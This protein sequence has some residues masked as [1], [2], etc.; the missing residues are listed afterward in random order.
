MTTAIYVRVSSGGQDTASQDRD[1]KAWVT[2]QQDEFEFYRDKATGTMMSR[3]AMDRL[4]K[5]IVSG[6]ITKVVVWRLDRLGRTAQGLLEFFEELKWIKCGFFSLRDAIDL[7]TAS[8]RLLMGVLAVVAQ[9][10]TEVRSERQRAGID[11]IREK[12]GG[13]CTWGGRRP[14]TRIKVTIEKETAILE[15][16][17]AKK[18]ISEIARVTELTR[19]TVY[20]VIRQAAPAQKA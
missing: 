6:K 1:L 5:D 10:E 3:P 20:R 2:T 12:N 9:F 15:M 16:R 11:A 7:S 4:M 14:G 13:K 8:G 17:A 19:P 18:P